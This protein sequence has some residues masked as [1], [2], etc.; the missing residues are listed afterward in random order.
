MSAAQLAAVSH[1]ARYSGQTH[2]LYASQLRRWWFCQ[3]NGLDTLEG[4]QRAH[5]ELYVRHFR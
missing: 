4:I 1:L 5:V 3:T 2:L